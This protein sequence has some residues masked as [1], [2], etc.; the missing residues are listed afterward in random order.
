MKTGIFSNPR[1]QDLCIATVALTAVCIT[2]Y[3][4]GL[5]FRVENI[6]EQNRCDVAA[7]RFIQATYPQFQLETLITVKEGDI[8][9]SRGFISSKTDLVEIKVSCDP[10]NYTCREFLYEI[11]STDNN[12]SNKP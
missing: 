8:Y 3:Q 1:C 10:R 12:L 4:L 6:N 5:A 2:W 9:I 11:H 7:R